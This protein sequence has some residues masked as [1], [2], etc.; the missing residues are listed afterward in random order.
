ME[1]PIPKELMLLF[2]LD[3]GARVAVRAS[4]TEPKIKFYFFNKAEVPSKDALSAIKA[5]VKSELDA[6]WDFTQQD[7][8]NRVG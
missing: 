3:G 6:L 4:G 2:H 8:K 7:V 1:K 5:S